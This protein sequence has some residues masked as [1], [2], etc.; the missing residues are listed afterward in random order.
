MRFLK[1][2]RNLCNLSVITVILRAMNIFSELS[3]FIDFIRTCLDEN[4]DAEINS[5]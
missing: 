5:A 4:Q 2:I 3:Q 1:K